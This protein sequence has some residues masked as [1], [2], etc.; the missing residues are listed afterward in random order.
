MSATG[1][2]KNRREISQ[3]HT[4]K[5]EQTRALIYQQALRLFQRDGFENTTMRSIAKATG[6][7]AGAAYYHFASKEDIV[8]EFYRQSEIAVRAELPRICAT[9]TDFFD[10][11]TALLEFRLKQFQT[12]RKFV[13]VLFQ[14]EVAPESRTSPFH[15][16]MRT[17]RAEAVDVFARLIEDSRMKI[18]PELRPHCADLLWLY[19]LGILLFWLHDASARQKSTRRLLALS[20][21]VLR[22]LFRLQRLPF[23]RGLTRGVVDLLTEFSFA[24]PVRPN[25]PAT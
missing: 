23:A 12:H 20:M 19:Q 6:L 8:I 22:Q 2:A 9:S 18:L 7:S 5:R 1:P 14:N 10:R 24:T 16:E 13:S 17:L 4:R 11:L 15:P 25:V 21:P 3:K